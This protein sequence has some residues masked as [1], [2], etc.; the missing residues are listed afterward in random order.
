[1][2]TLIRAAPS[3]RETPPPEREVPAREVPAAGSGAQHQVVNNSIPIVSEQPQSDRVKFNEP[4]PEPN[5]EL[6]VQL[7]ELE[8]TVVRE[9][10]EPTSSHAPS[11]ML[12]QHSDQRE[13]KK[14]GGAKDETSTISHEVRKLLDVLDERL[15]P[16][17]HHIL[18][19]IRAAINVGVGDK[20]DSFTGLIELKD[21]TI[22]SIVKMFKTMS[23]KETPC[24]PWLQRKTDTVTLMKLSPHD[25]DS[26]AR[27]A[28]GGG[29]TPTMAHLPDV[30]QN[31]KKRSPISKPV[32]H[33]I[34][35]IVVEGERKLANLIGNLD[36]MEQ[37]IVR[38]ILRR[39][40]KLDGKKTSCCHASLFIIIAITLL[41]AFVI[42]FRG[43]YYDTE[44]VRWLQAVCNCCLSLAVLWLW[45]KYRCLG[46]HCRYPNPF[47]QMNEKCEMVWGCS[48]Y[49]PRHLQVSVVYL[50]VCSVRHLLN[51]LLRF[52]V[53]LV[54]FVCRFHLRCW[55]S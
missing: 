52:L 42:M 47:K 43:E 3:Q 33:A 48:E 12:E 49:D 39:I 1:M 40:Q 31:I 4:Q 19:H 8:P 10:G 16:Q 38:K 44:W 22:E 34:Q 11:A 37:N 46:Q 15:E 9:L 5:P 23:D 45:A 27:L 54:P 50:R 36:N 30:M 25:I 41:V 20:E 17:S 32:E 55:C 7:A 6:V 2:I 53:M 13:T 28:I 51:T 21:P 18:E 29:K 24:A 35:K 26:V 14:I